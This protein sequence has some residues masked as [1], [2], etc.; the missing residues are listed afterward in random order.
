MGD[1][2]PRLPPLNALRAFWVVMRKG[3]FRAASED[4]LVTPQAISQQIKLLE[5]TL[6][7][8]LFERR[9]RVV[10]P[11]EQAIQ[12][13]HFVQAGFDEFAEGI[14]RVTNSASRYRININVSPY[15]ATR[16]LVDRLEAFRTRMPGADLRL[17]TMVE[18][19]DFATDE[20]DA[21]IQWG[22]GDWP[23]LH[24][25]LLLRD[26]KVICCAPSLAAKITKPQ[27]L[28]HQTLLQPVLAKSVWAAVFKLFG[29][30]NPAASSSL[31]FHDAATMRRATVSGMGVGMISRM[32][33]LE[34]LKLGR[35]VAPLGVDALDGLDQAD[36]AGFYLVLPRAHRRVKIISGFCDWITSESWDDLLPQD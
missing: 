4:L 8:T 30:E 31:Q 11:T 32:D 2:S 29:I 12:L 6:N 16:F 15:F 26:P 9:G 24:S 18:L 10:V 27:D 23:E 1:R 36:V 14:Q 25:T 17:T 22:F 35:L 28:L 33:A 7:L 5:D 34:D 3:S 20:V 13:S 19:P 21:A